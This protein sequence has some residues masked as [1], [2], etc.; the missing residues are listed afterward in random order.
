MQQ[1][2][3]V[4]NGATARTRAISPLCFSAIA[5]APSVQMPIVYMTMTLSID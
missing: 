2:V 3:A 4:A 5:I 1:C